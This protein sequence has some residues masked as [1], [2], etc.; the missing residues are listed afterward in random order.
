M[1]YYFGCLMIEEE[2]LSL[3][4]NRRWSFGMIRNWSSNNTV[5]I[6]Y[7]KNFI[8]RDLTSHNLLET[9]KLSKE[10]CC[11]KFIQNVLIMTLS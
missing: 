8:E 11:I 5:R 9:T 4:N 7:L 10:T 2:N 3:F 1:N 6:V